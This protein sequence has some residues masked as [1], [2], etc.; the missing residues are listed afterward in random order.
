MHPW[1]ACW[2][3]WRLRVLHAL[4]RVLSRGHSGLAARTVALLQEVRR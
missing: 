3:I 1:R 4:M 2:L